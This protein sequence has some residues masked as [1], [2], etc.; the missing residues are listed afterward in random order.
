MKKIAI[1]LLVCILGAVSLCCVSC[2]E[3]DVMKYTVRCELT[4]STRNEQVLN[5]ARAEAKIGDIFAEAE[6]D[7]TESTAVKV[8]GTDSVDVIICEI[9]TSDKAGVEAAAKT[10]K[11]NL[12]LKTVMIEVAEIEYSSVE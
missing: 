8:S 7:F 9:I 11:E 10:I 3:D 2:G 5:I 6:L 1:L 12:N 4:D